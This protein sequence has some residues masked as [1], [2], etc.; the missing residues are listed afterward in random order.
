MYWMRWIVGTVVWA[1]IACVVVALIWGP[2]P[3]SLAI[4]AAISVAISALVG[5]WKDT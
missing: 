4:T 2:D 3:W 5:N 1:V